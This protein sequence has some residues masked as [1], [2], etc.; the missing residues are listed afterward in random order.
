MLELEIEPGMRDGQE[1]PFVAEGEPHLDGE[2]GDLRFIIRQVKHPR[3][4]RKGD[5]LY[6]NVTVSLQDALIGFEMD[7]AHLDGHKVHIVRDK[8]TWPGARM[9]KAN[10]G[11]P[12]YENNNFKGSLFITFDID[13]PKG[14]L[15]E[16]DK[17]GLKAILKQ[18]I[19]QTVYNGL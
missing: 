3:F 7:I 14:S 2:P 4:E 5:D 13:F 11:M 15:T 9:R 19:K 18:D 17:E 6:A 8:I 10:E 16:E 12:N 1:Y